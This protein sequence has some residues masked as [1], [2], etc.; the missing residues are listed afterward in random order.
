MSYDY[1]AC[2]RTL[3]CRFGL[4]ARGKIKFLAPF[5][6]VVPQVPL[7][8]EETSRENYIVD[9]GATLKIDTSSRE[10]SRSEMVNTKPQPRW[11][12]YIR[13]HKC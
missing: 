7:L 4:D 13:Q 3:G 11:E 9:I 5:R 10:R 12:M 8:R 6:I 1:A 2:L